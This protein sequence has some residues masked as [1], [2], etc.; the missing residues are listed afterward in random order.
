[1]LI[2][3]NTLTRVGIVLEKLQQ[4]RNAET[5]VDVAKILNVKPAHLS[6]ALFKLNTLG[7]PS[8]YTSF[9]IPKKSGGARTINAPHPT[10]KAVQRVLSNDLLTIEQKLEEKRIKKTNCILAHGFKKKLSIV[11][12]G[13]NHRKRRFV[14]NIDL[15]DFFP[16]INFGRVRGYFIKNEDFR[17]KLAVA[18]LLAQIACHDNQ[19]PQGS[20][21]S[22]VISNL[23]AAVLDI[24]LNQLA[25]ENNC[26]YSRYA[27]D[28]TFSTS[29]RVFPKA[30]GQRIPKTSNVWVP[31]QQ[32]LKTI[33]RAGFE[34]NATKTRMQLWYSRQDVTGLVVN[35]KVNV[36]VEYRDIVAAMC[37]HLFMD[38][39]CFIKTSATK[40]PFPLQN[41]RGRL[42]Y[43][44]QIRG[45]GPHLKNHVAKNSGQKYWSSTKLFEQFLDFSELYAVNRPVVLCEG[46]TDN[47]YIKTAVQS[48]A[49]NYPNLANSTGK[50][51]L[52]LF[53]YNKSSAAFQGLSGGSGELLKLLNTYVERTKKF[54]VISEY[55]LIVV[56]DSDSGSNDIFKKIGHKID[57]NNNPSWYH[58][59]KNLYLVPVPKIN[60]LET[61]IEKLFD[62][63]ILKKTYQGK[64]FDITNS[65][66]DGTKFYGK[67]VFATKVVAAGKS[68]INFDGFNLLLQA[69]SDVIDEHK[70]KVSQLKHRSPKALN[71]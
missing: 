1:M 65:E 45:K 64:L 38:G 24:R 35:Q 10:L 4:L 26:T 8:K 15:K 32:L 42:A 37:H 49:N 3:L 67:K 14:F 6:Y 43:I 33:Q 68:T 39:S 57:Q 62:E 18:T 17:L 50:L 51:K 69:I 30:I 52:K 55:P 22:P 29:E 48:L 25:R 11:T 23:I 31:S 47:I 46:V 21:C 12:N 27:D 19:L 40:E 16:S 66:P 61:P 44:Y 53:K 58:I 36:P 41:L 5:L 56:V 59:S 20:P 34:I 71:P 7:F 70:N 28:I 13:E 63:Q 54:K 60:N 2:M 9:E